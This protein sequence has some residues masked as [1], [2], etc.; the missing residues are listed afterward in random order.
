MV[1]E[2]IV[3]KNCFFPIIDCKRFSTHNRN[4]IF[5]TGESGSGKTIFLRFLSGYLD[6]FEELDINSDVIL[7]NSTKIKWNEYS[8]NK[9]SNFYLG[10]D[11]D[12]F[13][14]GLY[15]IDEINSSVM[16]ID[17][18]EKI[19]KDNTCFEPFSM[20]SELSHGQKKLILILKALYSKAN[21]IYLDEPFT[22]L[23]R[24][25][26]DKVGNLI[27]IMVK[28]G[29]NV[30]IAGH[31][32]ELFHLEFEAMFEIKD[33]NIKS[34]DKKVIRKRFFDLKNTLRKN[35]IC[36]GL[37]ENPVINVKD[38]CFS[39]KDNVVFDKQNFE[40][41][42]GSINGISGKNGCGKTTLAK[43]LANKLKLNKNNKSSI[44]YDKNTV[45]IGNN[46]DMYFLTNSCKKELSFFSEDTEKSIVDKVGF[47][48]KDRKIS[49]LSYGQKIRFLIYLYC[50]LN[51][52]IFILDEIFAGQDMGNIL[53]IAGFLRK[54]ANEGKTIIIIS[55]DS[56]IVRMISDKILRMD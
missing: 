47:D 21:N 31:G 11:I 54:I 15:I 3:I 30:I 29:K 14:T 55:Q 27:E 5:F 18:S 2:N 45:F 23:D 6:F 10:Q 33:K 24:F 39:Y 28:K 20:I 1:F 52:N 46:P 25:E 7:E 19:I 37:S 48:I 51:K 35:R 38:L 41:I 50:S 13:I 43:I 49:E 8:E 32:M 34:I 4:L 40:F 17:I 16:D 12:N 26:R 44:E 42:K 56:F 22:Y 9:K 53:K 36:N